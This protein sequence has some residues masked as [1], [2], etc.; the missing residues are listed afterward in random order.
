MEMDPKIVDKYNSPGPRYTSYPPANVF[1]EGFTAEEAIQ[2]MRASNS[3]GPRGISLYV[4]VPFCPQLCYFC[5]CNTQRG[6]DPAFISRY[7]D[8]M[9][10]EIDTIAGH[11]DKSRPVTQVHWGGGTPN[12]VDWNLVERLMERFRSYFS[13]TDDTEIAMECSPAY[14]DLQ[15]V[16]KILSMG[17]NRVSLGIQ[18][19]SESVLRIINRR[20][21]RRPVEELV[22]Y[23]RERSR[24]GVNLDFVYGL[25]GQTLEGYLETLERAVEVRPDRLVTFSYAH[26][27]W[28]KKNQKILERTGI[29]GPET[30]LEML[31]R[32]YELLTARGYDP[33]GMDHFAL[34]GDAMAGAF[35]EKTL[36]RNFQGYCTLKHTG[37][38]Y[39]F[40]ASSISQL[41][42][43][44][45]QNV[46]EVAD[47]IRHIEAGEL[48]VE[49][50]YILSDREVVI[51]GVINQ[52]MCNGSIDLKREAGIL[53]LGLE[54]LKDLLDF[55]AGR[56]R[57]MEE[58]GLLSIYGD[59]MKVTPLGMLLIRVIARE[60]DPNFA[61]Y[62]K[63]YSQTI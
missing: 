43:A 51:R 14:L 59:T 57:E 50:G 45:V 40:G 32:G 58:D 25:P 56:F 21:P 3:E 47:Y 44:Y 24:A 46:R 62:R 9:V 55:S 12:S 36:H 42:R 53:G 37:Q 54:A 4:N 38:V 2:A 27:P 22:A 20:P 18:D 6:N 61:G 28:V 1:K 5:G 8:A 15:D 41:H 63:M 48:A 7:F 10:R 60:L 31:L 26:V 23:I 52:V 13:F 39:A 33:I 29:P 19:F 17:F 30:K 34:P 35:R 11:I 49:R 16:D